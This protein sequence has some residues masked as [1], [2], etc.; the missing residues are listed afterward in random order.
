MAVPVAFRGMLKFVF[1]N[2]QGAEDFNR[3]F[4]VGKEGDMSEWPEKFN[5]GDFTFNTFKITDVRV[6]GDTATLKFDFTT[7]N[8]GMPLG[9]FV[10]AVKEDFLTAEGIDTP[11]FFISKARA[12]EVVAGGRKRKTRRAKRI[13]RK[14]RRR[15]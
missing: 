9:E 11:E 5:L 7:E 3:Y 10:E 13:A 6:E 15:Y 12:S 1:D 14:T 4:Q 8:T 2:L